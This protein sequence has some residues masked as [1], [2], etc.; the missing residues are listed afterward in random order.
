MTD[1]KTDIVIIGAG[2]AGTSA[3]LFLANAGIAHTILEKETFPRDKICG[4]A[5]SGKSVSMLRKLDP[6]I[7]DD[8]TASG[9]FI[10]SWG[11][12]FVAPNGK[13]LDIPFK[14]ERLKEDH[15]PGFISPRFT[16][17]HFLAQRINP[18]YADFK[19]GAKVVG[20]ERKKDHIL[21]QFTHKQG[22]GALTAKIVIGA[23]GDRSPLRNALTDY[24]MD[25]RYY[26]AGLRAYY[27]N[28]KGLHPENFIE[29]HFLKEILPGYLWIFP[30]PGNR[31]N[32][33]IGM[34]SAHMENK[35]ISLKKVLQKAIHENT[36]IKER[37]R[38]ASVVDDIKGWGLP[39]GSVKRDISGERFLLTGDAASLIDPFT[40]EGIGNAMMS[41]MIAARWIEKAFKNNDFSAAFLKGY[42][43]EIY[44]AMW[45][46]LKLSRT[47]QK[48]VNY[49]WLFNFVV[50]KAQKN[51]TISETISCMF[52]DLDMRSKL[53][54]PSFYIK[55]IFN[56]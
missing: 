41:G 3:S 34:L 46:E 21:L 33:G 44:H 30:L 52:D 17:D 49:P 45:D 32:V 47:L 13:A 48:L 6:A 26:C 19:Q 1:S 2:P 8:M 11:V 29:L 20:I 35:Q 36:N 4:D 16:F 39:L 42:D 37:F 31:A 25:R 40:G 38:D 27:E 7:I 10:N 43:Q 23:G 56:G 18:R 51:K 22:T 53:R 9:E 28:V 50:N 55:L 54:S 5:L 15:P 14:K 24:K 12:Q